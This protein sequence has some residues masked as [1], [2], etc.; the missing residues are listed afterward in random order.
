MNI[1][2][3]VWNTPESL[4]ELIKKLNLK[5]LTGVADE[6]KEAHKKALAAL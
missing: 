6:L 5:W 1:P 4:E 2:T 3:D